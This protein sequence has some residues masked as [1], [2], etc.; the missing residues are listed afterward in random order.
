MREFK[1][2]TYGVM[3]RKG[4]REERL[5]KK[6]KKLT[7]GLCDG[8]SESTD[9]VRTVGVTDNVEARGEVEGVVS[10]EVSSENSCLGN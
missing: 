10:V 6:K 2:S 7:H 4:G 9:V 1:K 3:R 5:L 8:I